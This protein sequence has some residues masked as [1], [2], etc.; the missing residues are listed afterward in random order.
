MR[1]FQNIVIGLAVALFI[2]S[3]AVSPVLLNWL[4]AKLLI[5]SNLTSQIGSSYGAVSALLSALALC[6]LAATSALQVR[7]MKISQLHAA[8]SIQLE[9][10]RLAIDE[11]N[12]RVALGDTFAEK[13]EE[14]W[15]MHAYLNL[16]TMHFQMAYL[17]GA[18]GDE[19]VKAWLREELFG[20]KH[21]LDFWKTARGAYLAERTTARHKQFAHLVDTV[22]VEMFKPELP[23]EVQEKQE[24][25][26]ELASQ[27]P[28]EAK[29][30]SDQS[31]Q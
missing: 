15:R 30:A 5:D 26:E 4:G 1:L 28:A 6:V 9:L 18:I 16:W 29:E 22:C 7:Q 31:D 2:G 11:P 24:E 14:Q 10:L 3:V 19:G 20:S 13:S 23:K 8:R 21:G 27:Q 12:F 25:P 17:T